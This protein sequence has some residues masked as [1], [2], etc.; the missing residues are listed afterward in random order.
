MRESISGLQKGIKRKRSQYKK[1]KEGRLCGSI[2]YRG[3]GVA[4]WRVE[5]RG[6]LMLLLPEQSF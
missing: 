1:V 5:K 4:T 3:E 6:L 2:G